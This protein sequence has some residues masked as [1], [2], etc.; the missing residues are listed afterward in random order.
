[1]NT[2]NTGDLILYS[3][4]EG[5]WLKSI[6]NKSLTYEHCGVVLKDPTFINPN[7]RGLYVWQTKYVESS[8]Q[9]EESDDENETETVNDNDNETETETV[10]DNDNETKNETGNATNNDETSSVTLE[11]P[12]P[13]E[14]EIVPL[15]QVLEHSE[16]DKIQYR[17]LTTK[18]EHFTPELLAKLVSVSQNDVFPSGINNKVLGTESVKVNYG[19]S[20]VGY[21]YVQGDILNNETV[22]SSLRPQDLTS[23]CENVRLNIGVSLNPLTTLD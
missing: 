16:W 7:L 13:F 3:K 17:T 18:K 1:M 6:F 20:F 21:I 11:E 23:E 12:S 5:G 10:N 22:W 9:E 4:K 8:K 2:L 15:Q 14:L 19:A